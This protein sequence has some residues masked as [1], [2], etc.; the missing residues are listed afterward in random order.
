M[1]MEAKRNV[2]MTIIPRL[3]VSQ[4]NAEEQLTI[5]HATAC[6]RTET[7]YFPIFLSPDTPRTVLSHLGKRNVCK[8]QYV[9]ATVDRG[10]SFEV[11]NKS[12]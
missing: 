6:F 4:N 2:E 7:V 8:I 5:I 1:L 12:L 10:G 3:Y 9:T 11:H